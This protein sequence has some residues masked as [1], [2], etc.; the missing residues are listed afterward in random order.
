L[1]VLPQLREDGILENKPMAILERRLRKPF[2]EDKES[3][4]RMELIRA[5][6]EANTVGL[7]V[8]TARLKKL[9]LLAEVSIA[10]RS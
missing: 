3:L 9:V 7:E 5:K 6:S 2:L 1:G 4:K 10:S 8:N